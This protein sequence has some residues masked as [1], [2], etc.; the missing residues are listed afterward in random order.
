MVACS[1]LHWDGFCKNSHKEVGLF[2]NILRFDFDKQS[3]IIAVSF[4]SSSQQCIRNLDFK[5][6]WAHLAN[7]I[8]TKVRR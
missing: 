7:P 2:I 4:L 3:N 5:K 1:V 6:F 8:R